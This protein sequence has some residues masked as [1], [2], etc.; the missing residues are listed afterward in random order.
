LDFTSAADH[1]SG[2]PTHR[3]GD[4]GAA[5]GPNPSLAVAAAGGDSA[6]VAVGGAVRTHPS[7]SISSRA[8]RPSRPSQSSQMLHH[9]PERLLVRRAWVALRRQPRRQQGLRQPKT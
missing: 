3:D 6:A 7:G 9:S 8:R 4:D 5:A 1:P 2:D